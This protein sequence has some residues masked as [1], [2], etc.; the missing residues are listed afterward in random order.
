MK[1]YILLKNDLKNYFSNFDANISVSF[2]DLKED[3]TFSFDGDKK[4]LSASMIKLLIM[5]AILECI[6]D[7][8]YNLEDNYIFAD[9]HI[10]DGSGIVIDMDEGHKFSLREII[11]LMIV[12]SDNSCTN[13]LIDILSMKEINSYA[14]KL[15][16]K[17]TVL[18]RKMMDFD[19]I[20]KG[21]NNYTSSN[22]IMNILKL[23]YGKKLVTE[24]L[25]DFAIEVLL[26][27]K[28]NY[29]L[30]NYLSE[31]VKLASKSGNLDGLEN[32]GGIFFLDKVDYILVVL[33]NNAKT[34]HLAKE[35]INNISKITFDFMEG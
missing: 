33:V 16:L 20:E 23:I 3:Y 8:K 35:I 10:V 9:K 5:G 12:L 18:E 17:N 7:G 15:G 26:S 32:D 2:Y 28:L 19:A 21:Y 11:K 24:Y 29:G 22:D 25:S 6:N 27:Q 13:L 14:K 1:E 30:K 4:M 34:N 31:E